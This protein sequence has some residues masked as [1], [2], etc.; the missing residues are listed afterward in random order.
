MK[1]LQWMGLQKRASDLNAMR[2]EAWETIGL[3]MTSAAGVQVTRENP[4]TH[5]T[6]FACVNVIAE[7]CAMLP[8]Y[9]YRLTAG[10]RV[11][12]KDHPLFG[13]LLNSPCPHMTAFDFFKLVFFEKLHYGNHYSLVVRDPDT[14]QVRELYPIENGRVQPFWYL[15]DGG[16]Q[17]RAY[18][19]S[20]FRGEQAVF[21]E[22]ELFHVQNLPIMRGPSYGLHGISVW[23]MYQ[24]E[25]I[26]GAL[27]S[28]RF[29]H[30]SF[31]NGASLSGMLSV[32]AKLEPSTAAALREQIKES[33]AGP[34]NA[35]KIGVFGH[36][37]KYTAMSQ[38]NKDAQ[39]IETRKYDRSV[40]AGLLRVT[41]HLINDL[42]NGTFSN[43]EHLDLAHYK[44]CLYPH[45]VDLRQT[46]RK[47]TLSE[48]ERRLYELDHDETELLRGDQK[49]FA[50]VL[51][52]A[53]QNAQMTPNEARARR[54][55]PP[56]PGGD[57]LFINAASVTVEAAAAQTAPNEAKK[58]VPANE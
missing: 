18:R 6:V 40:I 52:K 32:D 29:A 49:T 8:L 25:T 20:G 11:H 54:N 4:I 7:G 51:E 33:Y 16:L 10:G 35:G 2:W 21:L 58:E 24:A 46:L 30:K 56:V 1:L 13:L 34:D 26:G 41:A 50:E 48:D 12:A 43:V 55:L 17:R 47:D 3:G 14:M 37:A 23:Q 15:D 28:R 9:L 22:D 53:V 19:V 44:H 36:G 45:L 39:L 42:E 27:A 31:E 5:D 38:S 57:K